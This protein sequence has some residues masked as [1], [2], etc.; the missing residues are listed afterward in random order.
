M[1]AT[2][3]DPGQETT[4][5]LDMPMG[6]HAGM[7][8]PHLFKISVPVDNDAGESGIVDLYFQADFR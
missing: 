6:M 8:G 2:V 3:I 1:G 4:V 7:D 5:L